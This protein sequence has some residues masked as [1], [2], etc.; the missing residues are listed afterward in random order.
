MVIIAD[1]TAAAGGV[2]IVVGIGS[3]GI[4]YGGVLDVAGWVGEGL[5]LLWRWLWDVVGG[6]GWL[7]VW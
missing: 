7:L 6:I 3:C 2:V 4:V 5:L 1:T